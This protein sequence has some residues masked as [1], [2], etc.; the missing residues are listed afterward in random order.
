MNGPTNLRSVYLFGN[1]SHNLYNFLREIHGKS[2]EL[3]LQT[4][5]LLLL[6]ATSISNNKIF[7]L[8]A[9]FDCIV[10]SFKTRFVFVLNKQALGCQITLDKLRKLVCA[11]E[12]RVLL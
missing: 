10:C 2:I 6:L 11:S 12:F 7:A 4:Y 9:L 3:L 1:F 5:I 8:S